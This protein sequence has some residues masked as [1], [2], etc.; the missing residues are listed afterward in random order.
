[1]IKK[2]MNKL[3]PEPVTKTAWAGGELQVVVDVYGIIIGAAQN[4]KFM[5]YTIV[6]IEDDESAD[7]IVAKYSRFRSYTG[8]DGMTYIEK[9]D[10]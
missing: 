3:R 9:E 10:G 8:E 2:L 4:D 7:Q 6:T 5:P 1:M